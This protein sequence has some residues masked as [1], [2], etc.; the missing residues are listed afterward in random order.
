[1]KENEI[2]SVTYQRNIARTRTVS[3]LQELWPAR[4]SLRDDTWWGGGGC[5][6][7]FERAQVASKVLTFYCELALIFT[8]HRTTDRS[9]LCYH[10]GFL[11]GC[12]DREATD[13]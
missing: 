6:R 7:I 5:T 3:H 10:L 12:V 2:K 8:I 9:E 4:N 1:M 11:C 13:E